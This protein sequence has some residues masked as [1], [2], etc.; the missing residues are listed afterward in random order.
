MRQQREKSPAYWSGPSQEQHSHSVID[1]AQSLRCTVFDINPSS[2]FAC[3]LAAVKLAR[4]MSRLAV[5]GREQRHLFPGKFEGSV[6]TVPVA[7]T[8]IL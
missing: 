7:E 5:R 1:A 3:P 2:E 8:L 6:G 4:S